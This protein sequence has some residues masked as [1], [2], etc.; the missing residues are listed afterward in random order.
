MK[1]SRRTALFAS[2]IALLLAAAETSHAAFLTGAMLFSA[3]SNG[4]YSSEHYWNTRGPNDGANLYLTQAN[5]G[6]NGAFLN[7]GDG[8]GTSINIDLSAPG[9]Y[10]FHFFGNAGTPGV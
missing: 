2:T 1:S 8:A 3:H 5:S 4:Q 7:S 9:S 6:V 10:Q